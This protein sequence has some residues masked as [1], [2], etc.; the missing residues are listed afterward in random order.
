M[1]ISKNQLKKVIK[2]ELTK[3]LLRESEE[4]HNFAKLREYL[5][6]PSHASWIAMM[7]LLKNWGRGSGRDVAID[8]AEQHL[9]SWPDEYRTFIINRI[10]KTK[11]RMPEAFLEPVRRYEYY[12][13]L[14]KHIPHRTDMSMTTED[15]IRLIESPKMENITIFGVEIQGGGAIGGFAVV[16]AIVKSPHLKN[17]VELYLPANGI[18]YQGAMLLA[19]STNLPNLR[20]LNL[21][22]NPLGSRSR[23]ALFDSSSLN[24]TEIIL[25]HAETLDAQIYPRGRTRADAPEGLFPNT[26]GEGITVRD[27]EQ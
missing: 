21:R 4:E 17:L 6:D 27:I 15:T 11:K 8:Y 1:K 24:D 13:R 19:N 10:Y 14:A 3:L 2:E 16:D 12:S 26:S 7:N 5:V 23:S 18:H 22:W 20:L 9:D 25:T